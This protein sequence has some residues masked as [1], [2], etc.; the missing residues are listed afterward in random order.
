[1]PRCRVGSGARIGYLIADIAI[2]GF[3][4]VTLTGGVSVILIIKKD[5]LARGRY[6]PILHTRVTK[7]ADT[8]FLTLVS[9][10]GSDMR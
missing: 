2:R 6:A 5:V 4:A 1:M 3:G 9:T 8:L 10:G 7:H